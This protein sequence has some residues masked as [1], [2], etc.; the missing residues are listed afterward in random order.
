M[1]VDLLQIPFEDASVY[2]ELAVDGVTPRPH[3]AP[4]V[5]ALQTLGDDELANRWQGAERR[6]RE[7]GVTYNIYKDP[8][9]AN[10]PWALDPVPLLISGGPIR[11]DGTDSFGERTCRDGSLGMLLGPQILPELAG[12]VAS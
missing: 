4:F 5:D 1:I 8:Q 2:N 10:R 11:A 6:I 9:G 3:W 12:I 7:N